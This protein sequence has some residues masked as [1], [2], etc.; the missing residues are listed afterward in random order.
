MAR[1]DFPLDS[2]RVKLRAVVGLPRVWGRCRRGVERSRTKRSDMEIKETPDISFLGVVES[3][4]LKDVVVLPDSAGVAPEGQRAFSSR[5]R[6]V[7]DD[8]SGSIASRCVEI[9]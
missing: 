9:P 7:Y 3:P 2:H 5:M 4:A 1:G 8:S 6:S